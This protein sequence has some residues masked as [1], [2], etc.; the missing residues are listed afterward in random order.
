MKPVNNQSS[1]TTTCMPSDTGI[2]YQRR[3]GALA[4]CLAL[5][6]LGL[7]LSASAQEPTIT[8]FDP[9]GSVF[10]IALGI[11]PAGE[12]TG[13]YSDANGGHGFM[14]GRDGTF[15]KFDAPG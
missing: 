13:T 2:S 11:N 14:R 15:T 1:F 12:V 8:T 5:C 6:T 3:K 4:L 10:T 7:N 9:P